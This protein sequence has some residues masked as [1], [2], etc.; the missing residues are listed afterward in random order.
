MTLN[1]RN[2][3]SERDS[4]CFDEETSAGEEN[5]RPCLAE[6]SAGANPLVTGEPQEKEW[7]AGGGT[8]VPG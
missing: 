4:A 2:L 5:T 1:L 8:G 7:K 3:F 6:T